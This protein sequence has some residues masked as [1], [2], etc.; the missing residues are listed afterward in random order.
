MAPEVAFRAYGL[1]ADVYSYGVC[2]F[3][4]LHARRFF[5]EIAHSRDVLF[6]VINGRR[7]LAALPDHELAGL[8]VADRRFADTAAAAV[9][10]CWEHDWELRPAMADVTMALL[11]RRAD[12]GTE[13]D[14][15][16]LQRVTDTIGPRT[17]N[18][19]HVDGMV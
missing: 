18:G 6:A 10:Q 11:L 12:M 4:L 2:L 1:P 19:D 5:A 8:G 15:C 7:P 16:A 13:L 3:E 17:R 9:V 14:W